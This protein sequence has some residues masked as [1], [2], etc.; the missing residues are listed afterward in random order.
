VKPKKIDTLASQ[1]DVAPTLLGLMNFTYHSWFFGQDVTRV[2]TGRA[3]LG[4]YQKVALLEPGK[5]TI[6]EPNRRALVQEL[7]PLGEVKASR[8][9]DLKT[10]FPDEV[11]RTV[12]IYQSASELFTR[13]LSKVKE[14]P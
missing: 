10:G 3:L 1:M 7:G 9:Y 14:T 2:S 11:K 13:G 12:A 8:P 4:T 5:L 6:L